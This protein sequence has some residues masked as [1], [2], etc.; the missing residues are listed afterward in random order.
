MEMSKG[1]HHLYP[2]FPEGMANRIFSFL[3][4]GTAKTGWFYNFFKTYVYPK[5]SRKNFGGI[6]RVNSL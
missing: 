4:A 2:W 1:F 5:L 6:R 3:L